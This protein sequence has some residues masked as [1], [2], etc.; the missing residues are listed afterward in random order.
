MSPVLPWT[1]VVQFRLNLIF[2]GFLLSFNSKQQYK[3]MG[4]G[5]EGMGRSKKKKK[6]LSSHLMNIASVKKPCL[7]SLSPWLSDSTS[8]YWMQLKEK[9]KFMKTILKQRSIH[10]E[11]GEMPSLTTFQSSSF[12]PPF[13][14][15]LWGYSEHPFSIY[16]WTYS[17]EPSFSQNPAKSV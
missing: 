2:Q 6:S 11:L 7:A 9:I 12:Q 15:N 4:E 16:L 5:V 13:S 1:F 14:T 10:S 8:L 3:L 17:Q